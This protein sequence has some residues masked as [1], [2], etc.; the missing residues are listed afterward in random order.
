MISQKIAQQ[1]LRRLAVQQPYAMRWSLMNAASPA[2]VATGRTMQKRFAVTTT[3]PADES[4]ILA[5]QRLNRPV[6]P[7]LSIYRP[8][9]TWIG[10]SLHRITGVA[11]S[12]SLYLFAT[13]YLAAP[14]FG[15]H[16]ESAS[17]VA[18]FGALPL[19]AKVLLK[20]TA[21]FPFVYHCLNGVRHLVWDLGRGMTNQQ[22]IK[23]GWTVV[24]LTAVSVLTLAFL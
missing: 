19:A 3:S 6:A 12:G 8:Q 9:I 4:K 24:G 21:A 1:S 13:A 23:S 2:A 5:Q 18:A 15:W 20:S 11:L 17:L 7:H 22:V 14:L 10:S 16:L